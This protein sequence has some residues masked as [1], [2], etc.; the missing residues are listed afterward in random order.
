MFGDFFLAVPTSSS[1]A[2]PNT[3]DGHTKTLIIHPVSVVP[4]FPVG[5]KFVLLSMGAAVGALLLFFGGIATAS[6]GRNGLLAATR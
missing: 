2:R 1:L 3:M 4:G 5:D 6:G